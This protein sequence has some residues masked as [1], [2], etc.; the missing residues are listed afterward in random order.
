MFERT[1]HIQ[2]NGKPYALETATTLADLCAQLDLGNSRYAVE[3]N[4]EIIPR[5]EHD[6]YALKADDQVEIVQAIGGG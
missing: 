3:V 2:L 6:A 4:Y 1:M 5:S